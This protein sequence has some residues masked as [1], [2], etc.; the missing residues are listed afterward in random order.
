MLIQLSL[1]I[2]TGFVRGFEDIDFSSVR[3][4]IRFCTLRCRTVNLMVTVCLFVCG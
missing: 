4:T 1:I 3:R 2:K